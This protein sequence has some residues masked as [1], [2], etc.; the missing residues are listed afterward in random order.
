MNTILLVYGTTEGHTATVADRMA[1][2]LRA[3]NH[4]VTMKSLAQEDVDAISDYD[5]VVIASSIHAGQPHATVKA[6][7]QTHRDALNGRPTAYVQ[8]SLSTADPRPEKQAEAQAYA[9]QF[10]QEMK[11]TPTHIAL[12]GG[13]LPF[14][15]YGFFKRR[16]MR[17][18]AKKPFGIT[19]TA[20]DYDF[21]DWDQVKQFAGSFAADVKTAHAPGLSLRDRSLRDR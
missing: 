13:A 7:V 14:T 3:E 15:R 12:F 18:L 6:F 19:D 17:A 1:E 16:L 11:W 2:V 10:L 20:R 21:T 8:V 5:A 4:D 9:D